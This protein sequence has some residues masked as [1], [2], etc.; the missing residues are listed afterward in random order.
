MFDRKLFESLVRRS[1]TA[2]TTPRKPPVFPLPILNNQLPVVLVTD[3]ADLAIDVAY[4][5]SYLIGGPRVRSATRDSTL[6]W[7]PK[8]T[9]V[10]NVSDGVVVHARQQAQGYAIAIDHLNGWLTTYTGLDHMSVLRTT[11]VTA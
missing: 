7:I 8:L 3:P 6:Y 11:Y 2:D 10:F 4:E 5:R 9:P 1:P